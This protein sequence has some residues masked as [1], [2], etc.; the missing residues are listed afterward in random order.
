MDIWTPGWEQ[1]ANYMSVF[2]QMYFRAILGDAESQFQIGQMF[3]YGI[4]VMQ[5]DPSAIAS[6]DDRKPTRG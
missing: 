4:G 3:Q 5:S 6:S 2:N 1:Q